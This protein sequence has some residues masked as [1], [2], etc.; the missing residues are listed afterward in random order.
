[1][2]NKKILSSIVAV[3]IILLALR[4]LPGL[5]GFAL[6]VIGGIIAILLR[7]VLVLLV[8]ALIYNAIKKR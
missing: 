4:I 8:I 1:M 6:G 5:I 3:V 2:E 7:A